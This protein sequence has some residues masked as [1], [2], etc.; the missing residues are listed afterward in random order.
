[1]TLGTAIHRA[2]LVKP[3]LWP[4]S[5]RFLAATRLADG[6]E[7]SK[8]DWHLRKSYRAPYCLS[9]VTTPR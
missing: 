9:R 1:M 7:T 8:V 6:R 2:L 3:A 4:G 5:P